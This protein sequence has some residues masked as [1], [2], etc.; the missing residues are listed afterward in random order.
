MDTVKNAVCRLAILLVLLFFLSGCHLFTEGKRAFNLYCPGLRVD[1]EGVSYSANGA[2][3]FYVLSY[4]RS[5]QKQVQTYFAK[6]QNNFTEVKDSDLFDLEI[7]DEAVID[8]TD[9]IVGKTI[10][11]RKGKVEVVFNQTTRRI[12]I[13][14]YSEK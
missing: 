2:R 9:S 11:Q 12:I 6:K 10:D 14:E 1:I 13:V 5:F 4:D 7:D 8:K 3:D